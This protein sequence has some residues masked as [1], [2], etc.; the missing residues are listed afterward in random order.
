MLDAIPDMCETLTTASQAQLAEI[1]RA[2]DVTITYDKTNER[3]N[4]A[5]TITPELLPDPADEN[6]RPNGAVADVWSSG[7]GIRTPEMGA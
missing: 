6:D 7:D 4:L 3:L 2:F 1:F 5:A